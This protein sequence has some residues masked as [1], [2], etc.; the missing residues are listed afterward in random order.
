VQR[1]YCC[2]PVNLEQQLRTKTALYSDAGSGH[3][4]NLH[5]RRAGWVSRIRRL[6]NHVLIEWIATSLQR[7]ARC[8]AG[9]NWASTSSVVQQWRTLSSAASG[10][11]S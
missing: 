8:S 7:A 9:S 11:A 5:E 6:L 10:K 2:E 1:C 3:V 4:R